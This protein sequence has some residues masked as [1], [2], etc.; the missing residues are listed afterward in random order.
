M[1]ALQ[2]SLVLLT[3]GMGQAALADTG[4]YNPLA[5][6]PSYYG[7][8]GSGRT[9]DPVLLIR[10][11][12]PWGGDI[13]PFF[14]ANGC[15]V[16][17]ISSYDIG[18]VNLSDYCLVAVTTGTSGYGGVDYT[19]ANV[20]GAVGLFTA[21]VLGGGT[22]LYQTGTWGG[23]IVLP[24]GVST[25]LDYDLTNNYSVAAWHIM[26]TAMPYPAFTG[27]YASHDDLLGLPGTAEIIATGSNYGQVTAA[28]YDLG[29]GHVLAL[30]QPV[31]CYIPGGY[32]YGNSPHFNQFEH[33]AIRYAR[34]LGG[35]GDPVVGAT[36]TPV[37]FELKGNHP[38]PFNPTTTIA[39]S[40]PET[41]NA[42]LSVYSLSGAKVATLV[43]GMTERGEHEVTFNGEALSSGLY[44]YRLEANG[45]IQS[46]RMLLV[47]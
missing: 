5:Q 27:Y 15:V 36:D 16:T 7:T 11:Y 3:L 21:Y 14:T 4:T 17:V 12:L 33:N 2:T 30:T 9:A 46:G 26:A 28:R 37:A 38:N 43:D 31:E 35:C 45:Q 20:N 13:V 1:K 40:L 39:F 19:Q 24:G 42:N 34:R 18:T 22:M 41:A 32:C 25:A 23:T 6:V 29:S 10:D 44:I 8:F 47:K